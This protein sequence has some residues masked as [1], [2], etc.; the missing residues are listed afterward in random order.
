MTLSVEEVDGPNI[1]SQRH[2]YSRIL[3]NLRA[4]G[5]KLLTNL[6]THK[7]KFC[8]LLDWRLP[9]IWFNYSSKN[10]RLQYDIERRFQSCTP[11]SLRACFNISKE[12]ERT[13]QK[14]S[15]RDVIG[16][17]LWHGAPNHFSPPSPSP[18]LRR[19]QPGLIAWASS[20]VMASSSLKSILCSE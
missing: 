3:N 6:L 1:L 4:W 9:R 13:H 15:Q 2:I 16:E 14:G 20:F 7:I 8:S 11:L 12:R 5:Q 17:C 19:S 10:V 18:P